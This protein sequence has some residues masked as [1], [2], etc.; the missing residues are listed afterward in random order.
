M[1]TFAAL[2]AAAALGG[3]A[4]FAVGTTVWEGGGTTTVVRESGLARNVSET[5]PVDEAGSGLVGRIY[6]NAAPGVVQVTSSVQQQGLF[7][8]AQEGQALGSGF[9]IDKLGHIITNYHVV[10]GASEIYV[11][12]SGNDRMKAELVGTDPST[13]I[14]VLRI[15]ANQRALTPL[16]LGDSG[17]VRVGDPVVAIGNPFGLDRTVTAGIVSAVQ[18]QIIAP[19]GYPIDKVIQTDAA[20]NKGNSGGPLLNAD[21][22]VIGVNSQIETETGGNVGIGFAVPINTVSEVASALIEEGKVEHA[23]LGIQMQP[24]DESLA[25]FARLPDRGVLITEVVDGSPADE[26]GLRGGDSR[27][28]VDGQTYQLGGDVI[29]RIG[30]EPIESADEVQEIVTQSDPGDEL[31]LGIERDG[32][33]ETVTV[34][35][36]LRPADSG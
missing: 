19:N 10:E 34:K 13:D 6:E 7:G 26:A 15:D 21:G 12:F 33:E 5:T 2:L 1:K 3:G 25:D 32:S 30:A 11:N 24:I 31:T 35:L 4:A 36:G 27:V 16:P 18:R 20:I 22:E 23:W 14:A 29:T 28:V 9:V 17:D 8:S